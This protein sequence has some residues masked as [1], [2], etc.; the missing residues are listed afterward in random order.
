M[1]ITEQLRQEL[2]FLTVG[3]LPDFVKK[4]GV[5]NWDKITLGRWGDLIRGV[6]IHELRYYVADTIPADNVEPIFFYGGPTGGVEYRGTL[7]TFAV[8]RCLYVSVE[9]GIQYVRDLMVQ[10]KQADTSLGV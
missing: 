7:L 10:T 9:K 6:Y 8:D 4:L 5:Y 2:S 3:M 1:S